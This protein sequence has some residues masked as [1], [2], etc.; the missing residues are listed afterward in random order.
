MT[1]CSVLCFSEISTHHLL[2]RCE[3]NW[4]KAQA[5]GSKVQASL[6]SYMFKNAW[7]HTSTAGIAHISFNTLMHVTE[8]LNHMKVLK[9]LVVS[10]SIYHIF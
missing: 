4:V 1:W 3:K 9:K 2:L 7:E 6:H 5:L 8:L 10:F